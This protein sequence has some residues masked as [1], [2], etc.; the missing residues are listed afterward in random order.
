MPNSKPVRADSSSHGLTSYLHKAAEGSIPQGKRIARSILPNERDDGIVRRLDRGHPPSVRAAGV[1]CLLWPIRVD[2]GLS[3][4][5]P[6]IGPEA[7]V[8]LA[9]ISRVVSDPDG[10]HTALYR[11]KVLSGQYHASRPRPH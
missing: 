11:N 2:F 8:R 10:S 4:I 5:S 6:S 7:D 9:R 3:A 1:E